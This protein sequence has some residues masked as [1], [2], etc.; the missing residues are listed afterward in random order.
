VLAWGIAL[1]PSVWSRRKGD[2]VTFRISIV[3]GA[4]TALVFAR[5]IDPKNVPADRRAFFF[6]L[7]LGR[8]VGGM[9]RIELSTDSGP[10]H[11]ASYDW[12]A[13]L[14]PRIVAVSSY[15]ALDRWPYE[16]VPASSV[17]RPPPAPGPYLAS[18][19]NWQGD[20]SNSDRL[21]AW[22]RTIQAWTGAPLLGRGPGSVDEAAIS[23]HAPHPLITESQ[24]GKV[25]VETGVVGL[26][27]WVSL[28]ACAL[29]S[30]LAAYRRRPD[31]EH[32]AVLGGLVCILVCSLAFQVLEVK[33]I[34]AV[35]WVFV[36][37]A[38]AA[39]LAL[40]GVDIAIEPAPVGGLFGPEAVQA[41][42]D[43]LD[44][45]PWNRVPIPAPVG[46]AA[47]LAPAELPLGYATP[48]ATPVVAHSATEPI[49]DGPVSGAPRVAAAPALALPNGFG[50]I[51]E[52][53]TTEEESIA[54]AGLASG[55]ELLGTGLSKGGP[56]FILGRHRE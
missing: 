46:P 43:R 16:A 23:S 28:C 2:G 20:E 35:F 30:L 1:S 54:N 39:E 24:F 47:V 40:A 55:W 5:Y 50:S 31:I 6:R 29:W 21:A 33:Q 45:L 7:P 38:V 13:W 3:S 41:W 37:A 56:V 49:A 44:R 11:D 26:L 22:S 12:A 25:L 36:G 15:G 9:D 19:V 53:M 34:A 32:L 27:L 8:F 48:P 51:V 14:N 42:R 18:I 17:E 4:T 52:V 10:R